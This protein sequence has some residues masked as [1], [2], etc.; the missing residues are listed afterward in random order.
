MLYLLFYWFQL[1]KPLLQDDLLIT[2]GVGS[3][4]VK[5]LRPV[6]SVDDAS[7]NSNRRKRSSTGVVADSQIALRFLA[8]ASD[9]D[10]AYTKDNSSESD[11]S[12]SSYSTDDTLSE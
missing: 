4:F 6:E 7:S 10:N 9:I 2:K 5:S 8:N 3:V 1:N 11:N 12:T